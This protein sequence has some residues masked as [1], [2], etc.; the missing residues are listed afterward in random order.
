MRSIP[1]LCIVASCL[2]LALLLTACGGGRPQPELDTYRTGRVPIACDVSLQPVLDTEVFTFEKQYPEA[3]INVQYMSEADAMSAMLNDSVRLVVVPRRLRP[4]E[5]AAF[6]QF[7]IRPRITKIAYDAVAVIVHP[8]NPDTSISFEQFQDIASGRLTTWAQLGRNNR[9]NAPIQI[10]VDDPGSSTVRYVLDSVIKKAELPKNFFATKGNNELID[11]VA[12]TPNAI[13][14][15][16][17]AWLSDRDDSTV[18]TFLK[19][20][21]VVGLTARG[22]SR[23][24]YKP[25]QAYLYRDRETGKTWYP[26]V[27]EVYII[28][29]EAR[30]GLA[31][32]FTSF[33]AGEKG[34]RM[35]LKLDLLP[36]VSPIRLIETKKGSFKVN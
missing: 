23:H 35:I 32:G 3:K 15:I 33:V 10:V 29:R 27:R 28:H 5:E 4:E 14:L 26:M 17:L 24:Y 16:G 9:S 8:S 30:M 1:T 36:A 21:N 22:G 13:G 18:N 25:Y 11:Y 20:V 7:D 31:T 2:A 19:K 12:R 34:Q 6:K